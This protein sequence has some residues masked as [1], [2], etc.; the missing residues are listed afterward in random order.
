M[1]RM[2]IYCGLDARRKKFLNNRLA[3]RQFPGDTIHGIDVASGFMVYYL[4]SAYCCCAVARSQALAAPR[5][6]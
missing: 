5:P 2:G 1:T 4:K 3:V 6:R